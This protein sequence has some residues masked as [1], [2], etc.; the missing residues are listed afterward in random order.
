MLRH[1]D[2]NSVKYTQKKCSALLLGEG[3]ELKLIAEDVYM[4]GIPCVITTA[5]CGKVVVGE[6][7]E[8]ERKRGKQQLE[9]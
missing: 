9:Y 6:Q 7:T 1:K 2:A 5:D 4:A 8:K 3:N